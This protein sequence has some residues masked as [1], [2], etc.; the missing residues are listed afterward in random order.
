MNQINVSINGRSY[1]LNCGEGEEQR[2]T[3]AVNYLNEKITQ[4]DKMTKQSGDTN[5]MLAVALVASSEVLDLRA[6]AA[7]T[8]GELES[9]RRAEQDMT[10]LAARNEA[11]A[12]EALTKMASRIENLTAMIEE[13]ISDI[14][15]PNLQARTA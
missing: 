4:L 10:A 3:D 13:Q 11:A 12:Q 7:T 5:L 6:Q 1:L 15:E 2:L 9:S 8:E 14:E